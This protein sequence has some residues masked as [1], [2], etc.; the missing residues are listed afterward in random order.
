VS[1]KSSETR[2]VLGL[3]GGASKTAGVLL[4]ER[5]EV[6]ARVRGGGSAIIGAPNERSLSVLSAVT[7]SLLSDAGVP[8][9]AVT[10]WGIGL[11]GVDFDDE[12]PQQRAAIAR[13]L[14]CPESTLI[15]VNDAIAALWGASPRPAATIVHCGSGFTA[16]YRSD[17]G[18]ER[19]FDHLSVAQ[20]F[21]IREHLI[22]LTARMLNGMVAPTP[23]LDRVLTHFGVTAETYCDAIFRRQIPREVLLSTPPLIYQAWMEGDPGATWLIECALDDYALATQAMIAASGD[24]E[25]DAV[26]GGGVITI[27]PPEYWPALAARLRARCPRATAKPPDLPAD[28][29]AALMA[30]HHAGVSAPSLFPILLEQDASHTPRALREESK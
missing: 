20:V 10:A 13:A 7:A 27:A 5:G 6:I 16:A 17:H 29:G 15:L 14:S 30:A 4:S 26:F 21:D 25:A 19:L 9:S 1:P 28:I 23:L 11:N 8:A 24:P 3:D 22:S 18:R 2:L 12:I